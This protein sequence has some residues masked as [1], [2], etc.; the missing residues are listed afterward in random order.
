[1]V[2]TRDLHIEVHHL[3]EDVRVMEAELVV[4]LKGWFDLFG[5]WIGLI[6]LSSWAGLHHVAS[7]GDSNLGYLF[8]HG[9][10]VPAMPLLIFILWYP[11]RGGPAQ[12]RTRAA[13]RTAG[14]IQRA[15]LNRSGVPF[16]RRL[17]GATRCRWR[18]RPPLQEP[19]LHL[20]GRG[21]NH[22]HLVQRRHT[23][24]T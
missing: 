16:A 18:T 11:Q 2:E 8:V 9:N 6:L 10:N 7:Y 14:E 19:W 24:S 22:M 4:S 20:L 13:A 21:W 1:M 5:V 23:Q 15:N 17:Q 12:V 3:H